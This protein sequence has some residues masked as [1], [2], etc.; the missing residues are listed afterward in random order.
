MPTLRF[1]PKQREFLEATEEEILYSGAYGSGKAQP[2][3]SK[4]LTPTGWKLFSDIN[5]GDLV[6]NGNGN[7]STIVDI[8]P[9]GIKK[10]YRV[11]L[12]DGSYC[13]CTAEHLW[14]VWTNITKTRNRPNKILSLNEIEEKMFRNNGQP[15]YWLPMVK[16]INFERKDVIVDPYLLGL[17]LGDGSFRWNRIQFTTSDDELVEEIRTRLSEDLVILKNYGRY[18]YKIRN[19]IP[20]GKNSLLDYL[21]QIGL[22]HKKSE[23]KF[24]PKEYIYNDVTTRLEILRGLLDTDGCLTRNSSADYG[25]VSKQL[26][27][28]VQEIVHSL[29][30]RARMSEKHPFYRDKEGNK[31]NGLVYYRLYI[32][33]PSEFNPF[34]LKRKS[35]KWIPHS[36]REPTRGINKIEYVGDYE[37]KCIKIDNDNGLYVTNNYIVTHNSVSLCAKV[38]FLA[39]RFN[40][41][42]IFFGRK[43]LQAFLATTFKTLM[44]GD[45]NI[46]PILPREYIESHNKTQRSIV[47]KNGSEILYGPVELEQIK[48]LNL[49]AVAIDEAGELTSE[50]IDALSGRLRL[51]GVPVRQ[52][53]LGTN[54]YSENHHLYHRFVINPRK[55][56]D[57]TS[58][59]KFIQTSMFDNT[60]LPE[61]YIE[62]QKNILFGFYYQRYVLGQWVGADSLVFENFDPKS[63][64]IKSFEIPKI[65][66][67]YRS[68]DF[69]YRSPFACGWFAV[70]PETD[71]DRDIE[72]GDIF[73]YREM[74]YTQ[75]TSSINAQK[76]K[77]YSVHED[78]SPEK[79]EYT[80]CDWDAGDRADLEAVGIK[81]IKANKRSITDRLQKIRQYLGNNNPQLGQLVR[82][83]LRLFDT[84]LIEYDPKIRI[85]MSTGERNNDPTRTSEEFMSYSWKPSK[86]GSIKDVPMDVYNHGIDM[87]GYFVMAYNANV[88]KEIEFIK[89]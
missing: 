77:D 46:D 53:I 50:E 59:T 4:I 41:G 28:D 12:T 10:V 37:C 51:G 65:W 70:S 87:T 17:L 16:P 64:I 22:S 31:V 18:E 13:D 1:L 72:V 57:G 43:F 34:R 73:L 33:L 75:R 24:I 35:E 66:K 7:T 45:G 62:S 80:V 42:R 86:D 74:Y 36:Q 15:R 39:L 88:W 27:L 3:Y 19:K 55:H 84:S 6:I 32:S 79:I 40:R 60:Y 67:R 71:K 78:G 54:P 20:F 26:S 56:K 49:S 44:M 8:Y 63:H 89:I 52:L 81:T 21:K 48:S 5:V 83:K 82:P 76:V 23:D 25:S 11:Y 61:S 47:L 30:G 58:A 69:G 14:S 9:Q 38:V 2:L 29:G 68:V 85:N